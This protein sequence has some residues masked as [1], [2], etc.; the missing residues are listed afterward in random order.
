MDTDTGVGKNRKILFVAS[1]GRDHLLKFHV[2][3]IRAFSERGWTVD[4]ACAGEEE[5]PYVR[6]RFRMCWKRTPFH[7]DTLKGIRD[8]KRILAKEHYDVVYC[9]TPVGGLAA[10]LAAVRTRRRGTKVVYCAH[11]LHF[12]KGAPLKNWLLYY[13]VEKWLARKTDVLYMINAEDYETVKK[14]FGKNTDVRRIPGMGIDFARLETE[15]PARDRRRVR[16]EFGIPE[17]AF[18]MIYA[19][20]IV[21]NKNQGML[22]DA[23]KIL[24]GKGLNTYLVLPG[25][26]CDGG[27]AKRHAQ[28]QGVAEFCRFPGWRGDIGALMR[29]ADVCTASSIREGFGLSLVEAMRCGLPVVATDNRGHRS[30]LRDGEN[31]FLVPLG[32]AAAMASRVAQLMKDPALRKRMSVHDTE[33]YDSRRV[34]E[35]LAKEIEEI[36]G[37]EQTCRFSG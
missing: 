32:D 26:E 16:G 10:R 30:I 20:D 24:R 31:G 35:R 8:L 2:P 19:A 29:A 18:V 22:V 7:P 25:P 13:P 17:D 28:A 9:H 3:T 36:A 23:L 11:G 5:V 21:A 4:A 27:A 33:K 37:G 14:R 1:L 12:Y 34:A 15:D 6:N